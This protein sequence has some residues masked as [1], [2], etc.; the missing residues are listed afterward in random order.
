MA[1]KRKFKMPEYDT[2]DAATEGA[3]SFSDWAASAESMADGFELPPYAKAFFE[4]EAEG[5]GFAAHKR[6]VN[7]NRGAAPRP[8]RLDPDLVLLGLS[9]VP[10]DAAGFKAAFRKAAMAA[11]PD[12]G[13]SN[14]GM[15]AV[16]AAWDRIKRRYGA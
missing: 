10:A 13:G 15:R 12:R 3:G 11:H 7:R 14:E 4:A 2:Y 6:A 8:V 16:I 1:A 9:A 5:G